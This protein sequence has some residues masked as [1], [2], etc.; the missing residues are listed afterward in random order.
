MVRPWALRRGRAARERI[1]ATELALAES[2]ERYRSLFAYSPHAAFSLDLEGS[3]TDANEVAQLLSGYSLAEFRSM[4]FH[5]LIRPETMELSVRAF[6]GAIDREPQQV[7]TTMS[8]KDGRLMELSVAVIPVI[9]RDEVVGVHGVAEDVTERNEMRRE[10][11]DTRRA[12]EEASATKSLFLANMSHEV[13]T[14]LTSVLA[15]TEMLA[16]SEL[17]P[18]QHRMVQ[19][20]HRSG[21]RLLRL[22]NDI[23]DVSR[24][25]AG[26]VDVEPAPFE[27]RRLVEDTAAWAAPQADREGLDFSFSIDPAVP[28]TWCGD[29]MRISQ[30]LT[31]LLGNAFKF[32]D[33][34]Q[35]HLAVDL[36]DVVRGAAIRF[37]VE[38]S[39]IGI[40]PEQVDVLFHSFSQADTSITRKYGGAGLGLSISREL[41]T[42]MGGSLVVSSTP[43]AGSRFGFALPPAPG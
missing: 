2:T 10:L 26:T 40:P 29:S 4:S 3:F 32:T 20:I 33:V 1:S 8:A 36:A 23:L 11:E 38:D 15:A 37:T 5:D 30:V 21:E 6:A 39:G 22:V 12:A 13:R 34:G 9:V 19:L 14:P 24:L 7:E 41:V 28:E 16:E 42:L 43:G 27:V 18:R 31:N 25:E 35:V 17:A